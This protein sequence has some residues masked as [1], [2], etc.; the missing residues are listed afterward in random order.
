MVDV[1]QLRGIVERVT[2]ATPIALEE[3]NGYYYA[4]PADGPKPSDRAKG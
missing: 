4:R 1:A 2:A 3:I